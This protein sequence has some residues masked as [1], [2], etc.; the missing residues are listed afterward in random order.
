MNPTVLEITM[1]NSLTRCTY[2]TEYCITMAHEN[3]SL[4]ILEEKKLHSVGFSLAV[5]SNGGINFFESCIQPNSLNKKLKIYKIKQLQSEYGLFETPDGI[6]GII[7]KSI[8]NQD[9]FYPIR[10]MT[11]MSV[12]QCRIRNWVRLLQS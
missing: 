1:N 2:A 4:A 5:K 9:W 7:N 10:R 6:C 12:F 11:G 8:L 3:T